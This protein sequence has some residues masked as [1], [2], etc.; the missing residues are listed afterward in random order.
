MTNLLPVHVSGQE[1]GNQI[2]GFTQF[3]KQ[4]YYIFLSLGAHFDLL[5]ARVCGLIIRIWQ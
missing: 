5:A 3:Y 4:P 2:I 1:I